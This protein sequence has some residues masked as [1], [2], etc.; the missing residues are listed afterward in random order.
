MSIKV[1]DRAT[2][3]KITAGE[4]IARPVS[5]VKELVENSI[6]ACATGITVEIKEGGL[7]YIRVT[8]NGCGIPENEVRTA[9]ESHATSKL[10][11]ADELSEIMTLGFRGEALPSIAA[12]SRVT[13]TTKTKDADSG[14]RISVEGGIIGEITAAGCPNGT[15]IV[16]KDMFF[17]VPVRRTFIRK[18]AYEQSLIGELM[19]KMAL[20][21]PSIA[22]RFISSGKTL[23]QTYGDGDLIHACAAVFG[24]E[25]SAGLRTVNES[26]GS[27]AL[28][29]VIGIGDQAS[30][31]RARQFFYI[32]DRT[33]EC[34]ML[35]QALEEATRGRVTI[36]KYPSCV[37]YVKTAPGNVDVNVHPSKLEVRFRDEA[38]F[39]LT[40][41]T[42][43]SRVFASDN[44][45]KTEAQSMSAPVQKTVAFTET[46][47]PAPPTPVSH[48]P[49]E[50]QKKIDLFDGIIPSIPNARSF[51]VP[52]TV[53]ESGVS[54]PSSISQPRPVIQPVQQE[55]AVPE[56][57]KQDDDYRYIG[58]FNETYILLEKD[59]NLILIDQHAAHERLN[60]E[61]Y[62]GN[63]SEGIASQPLLVP[64][65]IDIS[66]REARILDDS[67]DL[68]KEAGYE[69]ELFGNN[70]LKVS[71]VPFVYGKSD[72]RLL[73]TEMLDELE[74]LRKA[75]K[76]RRLD[77]VIQASCKHAVKAGDKL[78]EA[79]IKALLSAMRVSGA[80]P[81]CPHGRPVLKVFTK[82]NIEQLFKRI[83]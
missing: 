1:L 53:H 4:V 55:I 18:P 8:D 63:L 35:S 48:K 2:I 70:A 66:P 23:L 13:M 19:Q 33:V 69:A 34:R 80:P 26:E 77:A 40:A 25:Y 39:R 43:L 36:G 28:T 46:I 42:L 44:M 3:E 27:F 38:C 29:G 79:E 32:N 75:E 24:N 64:I 61:T 31:T 10:R 82:R 6:D 59:D 17:N 22:F 74:L 9:F 7:E 5:A 20:G 41:Q 47:R 12:I 83:Q 73:F 71:A 56:L 67:M 57:K 52:D 45:L 54:F 81:T 58:V 16:A 14:I 11:N 15:T 62:T 30:P 21:N 78:T 60:Y 37:L 49:A 68:L 72:L 65:V 76:E 50:P 51:N